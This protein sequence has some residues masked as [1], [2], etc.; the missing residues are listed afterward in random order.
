MNI[1]DDVPNYRRV[2]EANQV[3]EASE[4]TSSTDDKTEKG[5]E[6]IS[7]KK[8]NANAERGSRCW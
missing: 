4:T 7:M 8:Q 3:E 6:D 1:S 5:Q 2:S